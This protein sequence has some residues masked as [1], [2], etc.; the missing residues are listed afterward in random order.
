MASFEV[1]QH[2]P[3]PILARRHIALYTDRPLCIPTSPRM[4]HHPH[5]FG[6][7]LVD[8]A[9][10]GQCSQP[11]VL[12]AVDRFP[13]TASHPSLSLIRVCYQPVVM[14][15]KRPRG[16]PSTRLS[17]CPLANA[18]ANMCPLMEAGRLA[19]R[20]SGMCGVSAEQHRCSYHILLEEKN[21][22]LLHSYLS[23]P[24]TVAAH[25]LQQWGVTKYVL[26]TVCFAE[27]FHA[28]HYHSDPVVLANISHTAE[29]L[30]VEALSASS[31]RGG[32]ATPMKE[33]GRENTTSSG[34]A[35]PVDGIA[36]GSAA[37]AAAAHD[38]LASEE[39]LS[40]TG[41]VGPQRLQQQPLLRQQH[42][43]EQHR[44]QERPQESSGR[45]C[46]LDVEAV[47]SEQARE[48]LQAEV[49]RT[50]K[51]QAWASLVL[52]RQPL[53][54]H[55][56][57]AQ[58]F[59]R[60]FSD[61]QE[62]LQRREEQQEVQRVP[63]DQ[64]RTERPEQG[65]GSWRSWQPEELQEA[66]IQTEQDFLG[67]EP[68]T[69]SRQQGIAP[70]EHSWQDVGPR[71]QQPLQGLGQAGQCLAQQQHLHYSR[72][73]ITDDSVASLPSRD[74]VAAPA[75]AQTFSDRQ[76][77]VQSGPQRVALRRRSS[78]LQQQPSLQPQQLHL[79]EAPQQLQRE[80][81]QGTRRHQGR[82]AT[83]GSNG[84]VT[85]SA[86]QEVS[87]WDWQQKRSD[88]SMQQ[89]V[90]CGQEATSLADGL[91]QRQT[92]ESLRARAEDGD[93]M[94]AF[95]SASQSPFAT[96][97]GANAENV[98]LKSGWSVSLP[99]AEELQSVC[100]PG[101]SVLNGGRG[102]SSTKLPQNTDKFCGWS[103]NPGGQVHWGQEHTAQLQQQMSKEN[104]LLGC[105]A[106][107]QNS[108]HRR[109][110]TGLPAD[111]QSHWSVGSSSGS[112]NT[113]RRRSC[114][115]DQQ[116]SGLYGQF[117]RSSVR[118]IA[119]TRG[120]NR[121]P[122][123]V[124]PIPSDAGSARAPAFDIEPSPRA[125]ASR[126]RL[127]T[128]STCPEVVDG[129]VSKRPNL[130]ADAQ[131]DGYAGDS[132][133]GDSNV[134]QASAS[135]SSLDESECAKTGI[136][137]EPHKV[138]L[139][140]VSPSRRED[141][142]FMETSEGGREPV[143]VSSRREPRQLRS[144]SV[145][146]SVA[147]SEAAA[148]V[149]KKASS[150]S[151]LPPVGASLPAALLG[152]LQQYASGNS[153][154]G[155][156]TR[157]LVEQVEALKLASASNNAPQNSRPQTRDV[158]Q[159]QKR[160]SSLSTSN[161]RATGV[162]RDHCSSEGNRSRSLKESNDENEVHLREWRS[163]ADTV[164]VLRHRPLLQH[165]TTHS[166]GGA[167][168]TR[169]HIFLS[170]SMGRGGEKER[171]WAAGRV[172][173]PLW[174]DA[175]PEE[176]PRKLNLTSFVGETWTSRLKGKLIIV[177]R[178]LPFDIRTT[179]N[180]LAKLECLLLGQGGPTSHWGSKAESNVETDTGR[181]DAFRLR[182]L[183]LARELLRRV[184][185]EMQLVPQRGKAI[186]SLLEAPFG[187]PSAARSDGSLLQQTE[188]IPT[189]PADYT[190]FAGVN[191][192][193][194]EDASHQSG[195]QLQDSARTS[196]SGHKL[197][198]VD[199][200]SRASKPSPSSSHRSRAD[201]GGSASE[202]PEKS[203]VDSETPQR[204]VDSPAGGQA[205]D[206]LVVLSGADIA[207][208][209]AT[210]LKPY[211]PC[212]TISDLGIDWEDMG[213]TGSEQQLMQQR[214]LDT[215]RRLHPSVHPISLGREARRECY[216]E[217]ILNTLFHCRTPPV[218]TGFFHL[219]WQGYV[220]M[221]E[222]FAKAVQ[223]DYTEGDVV[224]IYDYHFMLLPL[225]L[226]HAL[227]KATIVVH[228]ATVFPSSEMFRIL[229]QRE[230]L[231]SGLLGADLITFQAYAFH[232]QFANTCR[233]LRGAGALAGVRLAI[234]PRG[235]DP[236]PWLQQM[237]LQKSGGPSDW[238]E[239][240]EKLG[241]RT[242][243]L[244]VD[245]ISANSGIPHKMVAFRH[246][247]QEHPEYINKVV[248]VQA[249]ITDS[250]APDTFLDQDPRQLLS[251]TECHEL[252]SQVYH[253]VG[254]INSEFGAVASQAVHFLTVPWTAEG[255][256]PLF[257]CA[258]V[259][260]ATS[261]RESFSWA[262]Y[263]FI[264]CQKFSNKGVLVLSEFSGSAQALGAGALM[265]NP[266]NARSFA[267]ALLD[268]LN[269]S[270]QERAERH[271]Y[272]YRYCTKHSDK[273]WARQLLTELGTVLRTPSRETHAPGDSFT[274]E[275]AA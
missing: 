86:A 249:A 114:G 105:R 182:S 122:A 4:Y 219:D 211:V 25:G 29:E 253:F 113:R 220:R 209:I 60:P 225:M 33:G 39:A 101:T 235:L 191:A 83:P 125:D 34:G 262:A 84:H 12:S 103:N 221:N 261:V 185:S 267:A 165:E 59:L 42:E 205:T 89:R 81:S 231:L 140:T 207:W 173:R 194:E 63:S 11:Y 9:F 158:K 35:L 242:V 130:I 110:T 142:F 47:P 156:A 134:K 90:Q 104:E 27:P 40:E 74:A 202:S 106:Y 65:T 216:S 109:S 44:L 138:R 269:M 238:E 198:R 64:Q 66:A 41:V 146:T 94:N 17:G 15:G 258:D 203:M 13:P 177:V 186:R 172:A 189:N 136:R 71:P 271:A 167:K 141:G 48:A 178:R 21:L 30:R 139:Q 36:S 129:C 7:C 18:D 72:A 183:A 37:E 184:R 143:S 169:Q 266:W 85:F 181:R 88:T 100:N 28:E 124:A 197:D 1:P 236:T 259:C 95:S 50:Q 16:F 241:G 22:P 32:R 51:A 179:S 78:H 19:L 237:R 233:M 120:I 162:T 148:A 62:D 76:A 118:E 224:L 223:Q 152:D 82:F 161:R 163:S 61:T 168:G 250:T 200:D 268:A 24:M 239:L 180:C 132:G 46:F 227:P 3:L 166:R 171:R 8:P 137:K 127:Q 149:A 10:V 53:T 5:M 160:T 145:A 199:A 201:L 260:L 195:Q 275:H 115:G 155:N 151:V 38:V 91:Q 247:L 257:A 274:V 228:W 208:D 240:R 190:S 244:S 234:V 210:T 218:G 213:L 2:V 92:R 31:P 102:L 49:S 265:V 26:D 232:R 57:L 188:A 80:Q 93:I 68:Q 150:A 56:Q 128:A 133:T 67:T 255:L 99:E 153:V 214:V 252:L 20:C 14:F 111:N 119:P 243:F 123:Q 251:E 70:R 45:Q 75:Q 54:E 112:S 6:H 246:F 157:D 73:P 192:Q 272:A 23:E 131:Q 77:A 229:P 69:V 154:A 52:Q 217:Q 230:S 187:P 196:S 212:I 206:G 174:H 175:P 273:M 98:A 204:V 222:E 263:A 96:V 55:N 248:F 108:Y 126:L 87:G 107:G 164:P 245:S 215:V 193:R 270:E 226:R 176:T 170:D 264:L 135:M 97:S 43:V 254:C 121:E 256:S 58:S 117:P 116:K 159:Q 79:Q 147:L 144:S